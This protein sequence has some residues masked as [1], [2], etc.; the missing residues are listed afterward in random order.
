MTNDNQ[1]TVSNDPPTHRLTSVELEQ[2]S[3]LSK[4]HR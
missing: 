3:I 1:P 2:F 4:I